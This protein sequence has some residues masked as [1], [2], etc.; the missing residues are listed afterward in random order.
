MSHAPERGQ[1]SDQASKAGQDGVDAR[2]G[3]FVTEHAGEAAKSRVSQSR[4]SIPILAAIHPEPPSLT[5]TDHAIAV[6]LSG[7]HAQVEP[8]IHHAPGLN[9]SGM[10]CSGSMPRPRSNDESM[11]SD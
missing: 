1:A 7:R 6:L 4:A 9:Y 10:K 11:M 8:V 5:L 2:D 3:E